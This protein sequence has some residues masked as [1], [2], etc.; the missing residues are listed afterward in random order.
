MFDRMQAMQFD[1][2]IIKKKGDKK[3]RVRFCLIKILVVIDLNSLFRYLLV[4][5]NVY[6]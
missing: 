5:K 3:K 2:F 4:G 1:S 6:K